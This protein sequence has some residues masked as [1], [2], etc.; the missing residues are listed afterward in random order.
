MP[1][2]RPSLWRRKLGWLCSRRQVAQQRRQL[3]ALQCFRRSWR[4]AS[5]SACAGG[6]WQLGCMGVNSRN[7]THSNNSSECRCKPVQ[8]LCELYAAHAFFAAAGSPGGPLRCTHAQTMSPTTL[9]IPFARCDGTAQA[10]LGAP[11]V[12][13]LLQKATAR[14]VDTAPGCTLLLQ[15]VGQARWLVRWV[16]SD[17]VWQPL[18][19]SRQKCCLPVP[20]DD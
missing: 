13:A 18:E 10:A 7:R 8:S 12:V 1:A 16:A 9:P 19:H 4:A 20:P 11:Q 15:Q 3:L 6:C 2:C 14:E 5:Q 17:D